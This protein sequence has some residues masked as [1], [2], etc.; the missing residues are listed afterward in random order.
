[1]AVALDL[2]NIQG[3]ILSAYGK[4]GFPKGRCITLH[5]SKPEAGRRFVNA[6]LPAITTALRWR[7]HRRPSPPGTVEV[8]RPEVAVNIAFSF[9]G[10]VALDVPT[11]RCADCRTS[12]STG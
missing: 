6:L 5:V 9:Y 1:M 10:L 2:A 12:S 8:P 11:A 3:N 4:L 7:S